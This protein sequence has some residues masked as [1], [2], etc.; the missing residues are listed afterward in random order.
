MKNFSSLSSYDLCFNEGR[1]KI[2]LK[3]ADGELFREDF[4][5]RESLME[6]IAEKIPQLKHRVGARNT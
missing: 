2:Q 4:P 6:H 3:K 1:F 5:T